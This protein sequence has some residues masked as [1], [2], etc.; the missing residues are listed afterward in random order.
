MKKLNKVLMIIWL[1]FLPAFI[2][3]LVILGNPT[4]TLYEVH[5]FCPVILIAKYSAIV[6]FLGEAINCFICAVKGLKERTKKRTINK[7]EK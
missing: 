6:W 4:W 3:T 5:I 7:G 1:L 2:C